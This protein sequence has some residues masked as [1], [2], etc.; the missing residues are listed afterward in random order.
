MVGV[1]VMVA[2]SVGV[3]VMVA[4]RV[5]VGVKVMVGVRVMVGDKVAVG[6]S[7]LVGVKV[8]V[9]DNVGVG[10]FAGEIVTTQPFV[11]VTVKPKGIRE[12][13]VVDVGQLA[14][15]YRKS[16]SIFTVVLDDSNKVFPGSPPNVQVVE[17]S[18]S[19][20]STITLDPNSQR[21][22]LWLGLLVS[23]TAQT[24]SM[25]WR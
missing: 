7:V 18:G 22:R 23:Y 17:E 13:E 5:M 9:G 4:V 3:R 6:D 11:K 25:L 8:I 16:K 2:V 15:V 19:F 24:K 1:R 21:S 14:S 12:G 20:V 10:V